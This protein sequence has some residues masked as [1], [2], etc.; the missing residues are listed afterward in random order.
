M[1]CFPNIQL[2]ERK[3]SDQP[4]KG[5]GW[6][7]HRGKDYNANLHMPTDVLSPVLQMMV[8]GRYRYVLMEA[9]KSFRGEATIRSYRFS[10]TLS[11]D[12]LTL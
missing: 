2:S 4:P 9:E 3:S 10:G 8:A 5:V 11:D 7:S 12:D 1:T 6:I